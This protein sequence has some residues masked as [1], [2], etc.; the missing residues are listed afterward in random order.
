MQLEDFHIQG[1][2]RQRKCSFGAEIPNPNFQI[3][4]KSQRSIPKFTFECLDWD[5]EFENFFGIWSVPRQRVKRH[6]RDLIRAWGNAPGTS[7]EVIS[8]R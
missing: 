1:E 8:E 4:S 2:R 5:L 6:R 7:I 3:P